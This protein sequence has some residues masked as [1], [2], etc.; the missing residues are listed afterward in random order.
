MQY[1]S[2]VKIAC[3][4]LVYCQTV[5]HVFALPEY[6]SLLKMSNAYIYIPT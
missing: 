3:S 4:F 5:S 6:H 1:Q 2:D